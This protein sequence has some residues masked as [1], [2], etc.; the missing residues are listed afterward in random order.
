MAHILV[1]TAPGSYRQ[2]PCIVARS[3][4]DILFGT[5]VPS[6]PQRNSPARRDNHRSGA[7]Q[8]QV[9]GISCVALYERV[10]RVGPTGMTIIEGRPE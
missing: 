9:R 7:S 2:W 5:F 10:A 1:E 3:A 8:N 6:R 4:V